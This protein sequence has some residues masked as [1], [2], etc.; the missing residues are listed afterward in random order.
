MFD[1]LQLM[2]FDVI[3][4]NPIRGTWVLLAIWIVS[5]WIHR[6]LYYSLK[7]ETAPIVLVSSFVSVGRKTKFDLETLRT[8]DV[9]YENKSLDPL[10]GWSLG[11]M[12]LMYFALRAKKIAI[13]FLTLAS[14]MFSVLLII[15]QLAQPNGS[16]SLFGILDG[17]GWLAS[18]GLFTLII[19]TFVKVCSCLHKFPI[20]AERSKS[21]YNLFF[22]W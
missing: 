10:D 20:F 17:I 16:I 3:I 19:I 21:I 4:T 14:L 15:I 9:G 12:F 5:A 8:M 1:K 13:V 11:D 18:F 22:V 7:T 2:L 6:M